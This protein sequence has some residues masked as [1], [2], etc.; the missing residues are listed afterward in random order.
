[1][2]LAP[3]IQPNQV[4]SNVSYINPDRAK[5]LLKT[6]R[7]RAQGISPGNN[8]RGDKVYQE[9]LKQGSVVATKVENTTA[10]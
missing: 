3:Q 6:T 7:R 9:A 4:Y 5:A 1:M 2:A 10:S 8:Q